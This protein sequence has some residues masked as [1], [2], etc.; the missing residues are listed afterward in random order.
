[1]TIFAT[2]ATAVGDAAPLATGTAPAIPWGRLVLAFAFCIVIALGAIAFIRKRNNMPL[3]SDDTLRRLGM[4][5]GAGTM[6]HDR[7]QITQRLSVTPNSQLVVLKRGSQNYLLHLT[8]T[9][10]TEIDRFTDDEAAF[11]RDDQA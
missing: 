5:G 6:P 10:A 2:L 1:M 3:L 11:G 9:G 8:N 4:G 7:L